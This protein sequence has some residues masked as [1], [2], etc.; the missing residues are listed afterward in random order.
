MPDWQTDHHL[1]TRRWLVGIY[2]HR[3]ENDQFYVAGQAKPKVRSVVSRPQF[4][5]WLEKRG[6]TV[7]GDK[8]EIEAV[9]TK[10]RAL[11]E[12]F[13]GNVPTGPAIREW[14]GDQKVPP[15]VFCKYKVYR[16]GKRRICKCPDG[17]P[18]R[19]ASDPVTP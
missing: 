8:F 9:N 17:S 14:L 4:H 12:G 1:S 13:P 2:Y 15:L 5:A 19:R 7:P 11:P 6:I 16:H 3:I 10:L 18:C